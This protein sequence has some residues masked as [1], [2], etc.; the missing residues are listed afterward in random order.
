V[1]RRFMEKPYMT[2]TKDTKGS[3]VLPGIL[4]YL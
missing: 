2:H 4:N 3:K 1:A